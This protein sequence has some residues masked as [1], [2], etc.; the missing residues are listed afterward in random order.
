MTTA[1]ADE[2]PYPER[3]VIDDGTVR[4][5]AGDRRLGRVA[6]RRHDPDGWGFTVVAHQ[7]PAVD[8]SRLYTSELLAGQACAIQV[9]DGHQA[10]LVFDA[11]QPLPMP[12]RTV[13]GVSEAG[14]NVDENELGS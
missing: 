11:G 5:R 4:L 14:D 3:I 6:Q 12:P 9:L 13:P 2:L 1:Q 7:D 10:R 8:G